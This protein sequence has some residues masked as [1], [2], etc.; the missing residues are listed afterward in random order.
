M[1]EGKYQD[2]EWVM[3]HERRKICALQ[4]VGEIKSF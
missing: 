2:R 4:K 1:S 3:I